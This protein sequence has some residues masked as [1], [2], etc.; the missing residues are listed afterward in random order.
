MI[1]LTCSMDEPVR[2][3]SSRAPRT[4]SIVRRST[5]WPSPPRPPDRRRSPP[6]CIFLHSLLLG[7]ARLR[8]LRWLGRRRRRRLG[9]LRRLGRRGLGLVLLRCGGRLG[10]PDFP[11]VL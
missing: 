11:N 3:D 8:G 9:W 2:R 4:E 1:S 6:P 7:L 10:F 5:R